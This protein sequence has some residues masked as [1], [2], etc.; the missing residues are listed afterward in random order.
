MLRHTR[1]AIW[2][3]LPMVAPAVIPALIAAAVEARARM[4]PAVMV[5]VAIPQNPLP[6]LVMHLCPRVMA[7]MRLAVLLLHH[8]SVIPLLMPGIIPPESLRVRKK[9]PN[10][11]RT[12]SC[13][14]SNTLT[15][16]PSISLLS[17]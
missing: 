14:S 11:L 10:P 3:A 7:V 2:R 6:L 9:V 1:T 8:L 16:Q 17:P 4:R 12:R 5:V 13:L 15:L